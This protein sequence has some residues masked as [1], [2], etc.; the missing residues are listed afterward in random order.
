MDNFK[1]IFNKDKVI[2]ASA[3]ARVNLIGEHTDYTGG[4]V[5]PMLLK[6]K[7]KVHLSC[8]NKINVVYSNL[9]NETKTFKNFNK[10][11]NN[12]WLDYIKGCLLIMKSKFSL[13]NNY[14]N[15]SINSNIPPNRGI[16]SSSALCVA[17][18]KAINTFYKLNVDNKTIALLA[19][20]VER[21]YVGVAGGIMDQMV[22]S[23][24][25]YKKVFF[26]NCKN[27]EYKLIKFPSN[28]VFCLVDSEIERN[29]RE[30]SYNKRYKQL[31]NAEKILQVKYLVDSSL[32]DLNTTKFSNVE[33][34]KRARHVITENK[35]VLMA[36]NALENNNMKLFGKLMNESYESYAND[37]DASNDDIDNIIK[38]SLKSGA[39]GARLT[40]GGFGGF[41][42]SLIKKDKIKEWKSN[43]LRFYNK[44]RF[45]YSL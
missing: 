26:L 45:L 13:P 30:S 33:I 7:T 43:M 14:L 42:V 38:N 24:G 40:G 3:N 6:H 16:S 9:Y 11:K 29:L 12:D 32:D 31:K 36:V 44:K 15:I 34:K 41:T 28:Y 4:Y 21:K 27:L 19:Q 22:S 10:S 25:V 39:L 1:G 8:E 2:T 5:L 37:F 35:R 20:Q 23:I 18:I 17:L